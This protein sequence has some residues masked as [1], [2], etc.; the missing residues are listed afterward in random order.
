M[1]KN[2]VLEIHFKSFRDFIDEAKTALSTRTPLIQPKHIIYFEFVEGFRNF[3]TMQ[4]VEILTVIYNC[5]PKTI[6]ELAKI[7]DRDFAGVSR[8]CTALST[9]GFIRL[10]KTKDAKGSKKPELSFPYKYISV[11]LPRSPYQIEF[12]DVA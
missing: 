6:Y 2:N 4:K 8:D 9:T 10:K 7:V 1:K 3:M 11:L 5:K 12:K